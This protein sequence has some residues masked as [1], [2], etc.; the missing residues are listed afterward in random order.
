[1]RRFLDVGA[2]LLPYTSH[3]VFSLRECGR[4]KEATE[5]LEELI[6]SCETEASQQVFRNCHPVIVNP[7]PAFLRSEHSRMIGT[8]G[9][10]LEKLGDDKGAGK[11]YER[12]VDV[13]PVNTDALL[14]MIR[15][16]G[17]QERFSEI[18]E[19]CLE[20]IKRD[21]RT[22]P[23]FYYSLYVCIV[24]SLT[25]KD[26]PDLNSSIKVLSGMEKKLQLAKIY[27]EKCVVESGLKSSK[28]DIFQKN[29]EWFRT[30]VSVVTGMLRRQQE[31][32]RLYTFEAL[33]QDGS[34]MFSS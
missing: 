8:Y 13:D 12:A 5:V 17:L 16:W 27:Q 25:S 3:V 31:E 14:C 32:P 28:K 21:P 23:E 29:L 9:V 18:M 7:H 6:K 24:R 2:L 15:A 11:A 1:M 19:L 20:Q 4:M 22:H 26:S 30:E 10:I 34:L 33:V